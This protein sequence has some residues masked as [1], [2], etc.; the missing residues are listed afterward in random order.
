M[1]LLIFT[2]LICS[3]LF[4]SF[5]ASAEFQNIDDVSISYPSRPA[6]DRA[7]RE[8]VANI[9]VTNDS[10][11][12]LQG[13]LRLLIMAASHPINNAELD[14]AGN[15][16]IMLPVESLDVGESTT[17][18]LR[19]A[20]ARARFSLSLALQIQLEDSGAILDLL[21]NQIAIFY[22]REDNNYEGWGLHLWNGE[23]CGN[24]ASPTTD[25]IHFGN[26]PNPYP[27]DGVHPEYGAYY[28]LNVEQ[29]ASCYNFILHRGDEKALGE[30]N[31]RFEPE[32]AQE[33]FTFHGYPDIYYR[34]LTSRPVQID[35]ASAHWISSDT[36]LWLNT[37]GEAQSYSLHWSN[38]ADIS[39]EN[40]NQIS[41]ADSVEMLPSIVSDPV[42][43]DIP[44]LDAF[45]GFSLEINDAQAKQMA[46]AQIVVVAKNAEGDVIEASYVQTARL[47][48]ALYTQG[49]EDADEAT[50]GLE[51]LESNIKVSLWA[52]TA[53]DVQL[54]VFSKQKQLSAEYQMDY[55]DSR[56]IWSTSK[57][58]DLLDK[59]FYRVKVEVYHPLTKANETLFSTDPY[60][61]SVSTNGRFSQFVNLGDMSDPSLAPEGWETRE[62]PAISSPEDFVIYETHIR[63]FS[64]MDESTLPEYRGKY[65]AFTQDDSLPVQHL[66]A[67][68]ETGVNL[69]H[70]MPANDIATIN[71]DQN[72]RIDIN[73]TV[74]DLC[75]KVSNA[76]VCSQESP[77][78][79]LLSVLQSYDPSTTQ[80]QALIE[81]MRGLDGFNWGYDPHHFAAPEGSYA[82]DPD[83]EARIKEMRAMNMALQ[84]MGFQVALDVV[85]NHTA[86]SGL[87]DNSVLD[88]VVPGYY[89]RL[90]VVSGNIENSTCCENTATEHKMMAKLMRDSLVIFARDLGFDHFRFDL[91]GHIPKSEIL[92][93]R[94]AVQAV[95]PNAYFYGEGW[96]FGEVANDRIFEQATQINMAGTE[97]GT[98][99]DRIRE[100]VRS[101]ALFSVSGSLNDQDLI[102]LS[103]AGN[104]ASYQWTTAGGD[105][106]SGGDYLW[107]GQPAGYALD[108]ADSINYVS[109]HD[110][111]TLWDQLQYNLDPNISL[112]DRARIQATALS[113]PLLSQGI[114]FLHMGTELLRSKSMDR[115]TFDA[116]DWFNRVDFSGQ[117]N[118]WN[119]GLPLAQDNQNNWDAISVVN[120]N[121]NSAIDMSSID[122]ANSL[123]NDYLA[124]RQSSPLF[125]LNTAQQVSNRVKF[126]NTGEGQIQGL[127]VMSIDDGIGLDDLDENADAILVF[128]N[129][130]QNAQSFSVDDASGFELHTRYFD[131]I[132]ERATQAS[133]EGAVFSIPAL[134]TIVFVKPQLG[135]Q[136]FGLS[137][138][139]PYGAAP[140]YLRG[141][142]NAW[143]DDLPFEYQGEERYSIE[144]ELEVGDYE[145]KIADQ[146]FADVNIGGGF[147]VPVAS[148]VELSNF[149]NNLS[150]SI[151]QAAVYRF[152][153]N[154]DNPNNPS[155]LVDSDAIT[156]PVDT[157]PYSNDI[158]LRGSMNSWGTSEEYRFE[159][160][161]QNEYRVSVALSDETHVFKIASS[162]WQTNIGGS[163]ADQNVIQDTPW[164][165]TNDNNSQNLTFDASQS[166][167]YDLTL[168]VNN[169]NAPVLNIS[170]GDAPFGELFVRGAMNSWG[171][172]DPMIYEGFGEY[173]A[174][175]SLS[176]ESF[177]FKVANEG[178]DSQFGAG[179]EVAVEESVTIYQNGDD[180]ILII[181]Q[182]GFYE[183]TLDVFSE[184]KTIQ[185]NQ[186]EEIP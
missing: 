76:E 20:M 10:A 12:E 167:N 111:E 115:N 155:L 37:K 127:I 112:N 171:T 98:F 182:D 146:N 22:Q 45:N 123:F 134:S 139:P 96:N 17:V 122:L 108:P 119:I 185:V 80:A 67:L 64:A 58:A 21:D 133:V 181:P 72:Q 33:G 176:A 62:R 88:K 114:P 3:V 147:E 95:R 24:Y 13:Q 99:N 65:L 41:S 15:Q 28:I 23:G 180:G 120:A 153:L 9:T 137:A 61:V 161:G 106:I 165:L 50:L 105:F 160:Q 103:M 77:D 42:R 31:S 110:N 26:W 55:D 173:T 184:P 27:H 148:E 177:N 174:T 52:P 92:A 44:H 94:E 128:I 104:L 178:W 81:S 84:S 70:I 163:T 16:F 166:G 124:I 93:A 79:S 162:D 132:D 141:S 7:N 113:I 136:G 60:S 140:I 97:V 40:G 59:Q 89:H 145:F 164:E 107:N 151:T 43:S 6:F 116:G 90:N 130:T 109:K 25:S 54:Q 85:Y 56:G 30:A 168:D 68:K 74:A 11:N 102:R 86:S 1:K 63:D 66:S 169:P 186:V 46:K 19:M 8:L 38:E 121:S 35:G 135:E 69:I 138:L 157:G 156:P 100:A 57:P 129:G 143:S 179:T 149:G 48:D 73:N 14:E 36:L 39:I 87:F 142:M 71:E 150:L 78:A 83:G 158:Y 91:M 126:H 2:L 51:Y 183:F 34:A 152:E 49:A 144:I 117:T 125:R 118:N 82:T 172:S 75:S 47:L 170:D 131:A 53:T 18:E 159:Y 154:A 101:A 29:G 32:F 175:L 5:W 4:P